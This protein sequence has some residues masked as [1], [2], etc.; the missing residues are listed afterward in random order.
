MEKIFKM[1]NEIQNYAWGTKDFIAQLHGVN[2][3][4]KPQAEMWMGAHPKAPSMV[5]V[6]NEKKSLTDLIT[7]YP[8]HFLGVKIA[9]KFAG[10]L[11]FLLKIL[12]AN[13]ALSIQ[14]HP[15]KIQAELGFA[16][17]NNCGVELK[18]FDRNYK[19]DNHK[20]EL[21]CALT[22]FDAMCGFRP[23]AEIHDFWQRHQ[24]WTEG[25][26]NFLHNPQPET[27]KRM[28]FGFMNLSRPEQKEVVEKT[29]E[30]LQSPR[31]ESEANIITWMYKLN[32][33]YPGDIGVL[34]PSYLNTIQLQP[35]EALYLQA[36]LIHSYLQGSGIEIMANSDNVLRGGLTPKHIDLSE[37]EKTLIFSFGEVEKI[38]GENLETGRLYPTLAPEFE[39]IYQNKME[40]INKV[41]GPEVVLCT[42]GEVTLQ[43]GDIVQLKAGESAFVCAANCEYKL[44]GQ[45]EVFRAR[46]PLKDQA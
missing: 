10:R 43:A 41:N 33:I 17:E 44:I 20:P 25:S 3:S 22:K 16:A 7:Q 18:S 37:L 27:F 4:N 21:I 11:P 32:E 40:M 1:D 6:N 2:S 29:L 34:A 38:E 46:I 8:E 23:L 9:K 35:G 13:S 31:N 24:I 12:S 39:L 5:W 14:V 30:K 15:D 28:F 42:A 36:G 26:R 19:D 45:G